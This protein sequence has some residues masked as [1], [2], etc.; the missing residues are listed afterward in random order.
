[1]PANGEKNQYPENVPEDVPI[2]STYAAPAISQA[3]DSPKSG[4]NTE[5][6]HPEGLSDHY[7]ES[8]PWR[9]SSQRSRPAHRQT[10]QRWSL[11]PPQHPLSRTPYQSDH[12][13]QPRLHSKQS[14]RYVS[15]TTSEAARQLQT[16]NVLGDKFKRVSPTSHSLQDQG[17]GPLSCGFPR[18]DATHK[19]S[20]TVHVFR[21]TRLRPRTGDETSQPFDSDRSSSNRLGEEAGSTADG[22]ATRLSNFVGSPKSTSIPN[23]ATKYPTSTD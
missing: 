1:M 12:Q 3:S 11:P 2:T 19:C 13:D 5:E 23:Q 16:R 14:E 6:E 7:A 18:P 8:L 21:E 15:W 4:R 10:C 17:I 9:Y 22:S 20:N